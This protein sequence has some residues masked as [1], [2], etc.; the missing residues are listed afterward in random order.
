MSVL[1]VQ[2]L[3]TASAKHE[4]AGNALGH[5]GF[6]SL[7]TQWVS[8]PGVA[9]GEAPA[10]AAGVSASPQ[11]RSS[12]PQNTKEPFGASLNSPTPLV[13]AN[14]E[15][16]GLAALRERLRTRLMLTA[17]SSV[18]REVSFDLT[19]PTFQKYPCTHTHAH[20]HTHAGTDTDTH[21]PPQRSPPSAIEFSNHVSTHQIATYF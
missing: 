17:G 4:E 8:K 1:I 10:G 18:V 15:L 21:S 16:F 6:L 20:S 11:L 19:S 12:W 3:E 7:I 9:A 5:G 14:G 2:D 13:P